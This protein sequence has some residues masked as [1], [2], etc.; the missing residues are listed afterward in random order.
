M[1]VLEEDPVRSDV[2]AVVRGRLA[3]IVRDQGHLGRLHRLDQFDE[4]SVGIALDVELPIRELISHQRL[5][6]GHVRSANV[7]LVRPRMDGQPVRAGL[8]RDP[9]D[10]D[11]ARPRQVAP[12][13]KHRNGVEVD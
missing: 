6:V 12:V 8:Q 11:D 7:A 1:I 5:E 2:P 10:A 3:D 13:P 9:A 4:T